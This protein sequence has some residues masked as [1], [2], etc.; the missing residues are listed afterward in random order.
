MKPV[1]LTFIEK[2]RI[3]PA[4]WQFIFV[5]DKPLPPFQPGQFFLARTGNMF[6]AYLPRPLFLAPCDEV[7]GNWPVSRFQLTLSARHLADR[8]LAWLFSCPPARKI[9]AFG[10]LGC[11][12][13]LPAT[14]KNLLVPID[15]ELGM[16]VFLV[17]S[18]FTMRK[19]LNVTL[20]FES[21]NPLP[22][23]IV[24]RFPPHVEITT[25]LTTDR[26]LWPDAIIAIGGIPFYQRLKARLSAVRLRPAPGLAQILLADAPLRPCGVGA[27]GLCAVPT[28]AGSRLACLAGPV[29]DL[30]TLD[31]EVLADD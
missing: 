7:A 23:A 22:A 17:G 20:A 2:T 14:T 29:F 12:F 4:M 26:L 13:T 1:T 25:T 21:K 24:R 16:G 30:A 19:S 6:S 27:C 18:L 11:G 9:D 31:L 8:G 28:A 3:A 10:P 5:A 15:F